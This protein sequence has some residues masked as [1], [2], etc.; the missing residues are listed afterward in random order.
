MRTAYLCNTGDFMKCDNCNSL[1]EKFI[2]IATQNKKFCYNCYGSIFEKKLKHNLSRHKMAVANDVI[3]LSNK[4][5]A[6][7]IAVNHVFHKLFD[8][9]PKIKFGRRGKIV[10]YS[11]AKDILIKYFEDIKKGKKF[12]LKITIMP[13]YNFAP[14]DFEFYCTARSLR[15]A[16][17]KKAKKP[18]DEFI[19]RILIVK[20]GGLYSFVKFMEDA[21]LITA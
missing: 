14:E 6:V 12:N 4:K 13:G 7:V 17:Q 9:H 10:D 2:Y 5:S 21:G 11:T 1:Q 16:K 20:P 8:K 15:Y 3:L 18:E 19:E